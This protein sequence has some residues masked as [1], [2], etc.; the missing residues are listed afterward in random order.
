MPLQK[1]RLSSAE[2]AAKRCTD[3]PT[4]RMH[5]SACYGAVTYDTSH[6]SAARGIHTPRHM[7][8]LLMNCAC[9]AA[10]QPHLIKYVTDGAPPHAVAAG[11][12]LF[13]RSRA[14]LSLLA[15]S[16]SS[17]SERATIWRHGRHRPYDASISADGQKRSQSRSSR[18]M[19]LGC[20]DGTPSAA[21]SGANK[22]VSDAGRLRAS[23]ARAP[24]T[25]AVVLASPSSPSPTSKLSCKQS[26]GDLLIAPTVDAKRI[27][28]AACERWRRLRLGAS[29]KRYVL[30]LP[31]AYIADQLDQPKKGAH[32]EQP[33]HDLFLLLQQGLLKRHVVC[34]RH[35]QHPQR[36]YTHLATGLQ[37]ATEDL[38]RADAL[39]LTF[40]LVCCCCWRTFFV[41]CLWR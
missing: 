19:A 11:A 28:N 24:I 41:I 2:L 21:L 38:D 37:R 35:R 7:C 18:V 40:G 17:P 8:R 25:A 36:L 5:L 15:R 4:V 39:L 27:V 14:A 32:L 13:I 1:V 3:T 20:V 6:V 10:A 29:G 16:V 30:T 26:W 33:G 34:C 31:G 9:S 23:E 22:C 12:L